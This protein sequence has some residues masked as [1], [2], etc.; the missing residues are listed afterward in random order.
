M[1][2]EEL[3]SLLD[4]ERRFDATDTLELTVADRLDEDDDSGGLFGGLLK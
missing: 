3:R 4:E 2:P 1:T